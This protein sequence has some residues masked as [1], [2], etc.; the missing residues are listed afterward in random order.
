MKGNLAIAFS[1][2]HIHNYKQFSN[3]RLDNTILALR[4]IFETADKNGAKYILFEGDLYNQQVNIPVIVSDALKE[5]FL[6]LEKTYPNILFI[7]ISGN[8]DQATKNTY[9]KSGITALTELDRLF[10]NF[11]LIDNDTFAIGENIEIHGLPYYEYKEHFSKALDEIEIYNDKINI[12]LTHQTPTFE[13]SVIPVDIDIADERLQKFDLILNG[14]IHKHE[15]LSE[16][17]INVGSTI[18]RD[19]DD[20]GVEKGF[21]AI[22]LENPKEYIFKSLSN[23]FPQVLIKE[24]GEEL[25]DWEKEQ[26]IMWQAKL[27][28]DDTITLDVNKFES[29]LSNKVLL[30]NYLEAIGESKRLEIGKKFL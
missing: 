5:E 15:V 18:P 6:Y 12:L 16:N 14:H 7:A 17:F 3:T 21:L 25:T 19:K 8:H 20:V 26:Y 28:Q 4:K 1:D 9:E 10:K 13:N 29:T 11:I 23:D 2:L 30:A 22:N 27:V 24:E